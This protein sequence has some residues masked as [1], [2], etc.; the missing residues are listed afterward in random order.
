MIFYALIWWAPKVALK[1]ES[2]K[3]GSSEPSGAYKVFM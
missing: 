1:H 3:Q 2:V